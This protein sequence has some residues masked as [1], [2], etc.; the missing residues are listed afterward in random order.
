M[1]L[2]EEQQLIRDAMRQFAQMR[3]PAANVNPLTG[4]P[5]P[6]AAPADGDAAIMQ[7]QQAMGQG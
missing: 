1:V 5:I 4:L 6:D 2:T 3:G 7:L